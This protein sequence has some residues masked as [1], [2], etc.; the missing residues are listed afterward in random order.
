M[1]GQ[2]ALED[3]AKQK[4]LRHTLTPVK[5]NT[6]DEIVGCINSPNCKS[7]IPVVAQDQ[8]LKLCH[9]QFYQK[10]DKHVCLECVKHDLIVK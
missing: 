8:K 6:P 1:C 3:H 7:G 4:G 9:V 10:D 2:C 5:G